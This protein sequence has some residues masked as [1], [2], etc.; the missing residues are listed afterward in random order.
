MPGLLPEAA[1]AV[2]CEAKIRKSV[3]DTNPQSLVVCLNRP[4]GVLSG[5]H[6]IDRT[7]RWHRSIV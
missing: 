2:K 3:A 7:L 6:K 1:E 4:C 5:E